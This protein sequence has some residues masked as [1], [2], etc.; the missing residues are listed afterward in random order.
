MKFLLPQGKSAADL[1]TEMSQALGEKC[2]S[3][4]TVTTWVSPFKTEHFT[5]EDKPHSG[6]PTTSTDP[7]TGDAVHKLI[8][9]DQ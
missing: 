8:L 1:H 5:V 9:E 2:P 7:A 4:S 3:Y 6:R